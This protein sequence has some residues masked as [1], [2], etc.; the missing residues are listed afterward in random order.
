MISS[1]LEFAK[2][3]LFQTTD[4]YWSFER[5]K[6]TYKTFILSEKEKLY[7]MKRISPKNLSL[8]ECMYGKHDDENAVCYLT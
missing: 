5:F 8:W 7:V 6:V 1:L 2:V 3:R 4:A